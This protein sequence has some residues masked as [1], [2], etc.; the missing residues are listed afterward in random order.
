[1]IKR[2]ETIVPHC[3]LLVARLQQVHTVAVL[4]TY[5]IIFIFNNTYRIF[6]EEEEES[7]SIIQPSNDLRIIIKKGN[8]L[9]EGLTG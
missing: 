7:R 4:L 9:Y 1:M 6:V 2:N 5:H 3:C 8:M